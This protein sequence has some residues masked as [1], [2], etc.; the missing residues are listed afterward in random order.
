MSEDNV[1][2]KQEVHDTERFGMENP[3]T[4]P[5]M[6]KGEHGTRVLKN[7]KV[8]EVR[9]L[10]GNHVLIYVITEKGLVISAQG[11]GE[12]RNQ[13]LHLAEKKPVYCAGNISVQNG[14]VTSINEQSGGY[15]PE[16][17]HLPQLV[18]RE[19]ARNGFTEARSKFRAS[20]GQEP[21]ASAPS[22]APPR[23]MGASDA[24]PASTSS[25]VS[26]EQK[27]ASVSSSAPTAPE[28]KQEIKD[29]VERKYHPV[30][31]FMPPLA[32]PVTEQELRTVLTYTQAIFSGV[33]KGVLRC[34]DDVLHPIDNI[35]Y[36]L[37]QLVSDASIIA[38]ASTLQSASNHPMLEGV[39]V[40]HTLIKRDSKLYQDA[41]KRMR[42]RVNGLEQS[43]S[44]FQQA[45]S[46]ERVEKLAEFSTSLL[47][48]GFM[49]KSA[50][51]FI[52][53]NRFGQLSP[54]TF[55]I[56]G[57]SGPAEWLELRPIQ[58]LTLQEIRAMRDADLM[59]V[60]TQKG[61]LIITEQ[62]YDH[63][64]LAQGKPVRGAGDVY[65]ENGR[66][67]R[68]DSRSG[69]FAPQSENLGPLVEHVFQ[70]NGF[71]EVKGQFV[72]W[73]K[74]MLPYLEPGETRTIP[75]ISHDGVSSSLAQGGS[76]AFFKELYKE[77]GMFSGHEQSLSPF[78]LSKLLKTPLPDTKIAAPAAPVMPVRASNPQRQQQQ[79]R[80]QQVLVQE[81]LRDSALNPAVPRAQYRMLPPSSGFAPR[82][83][84]LF[85]P[86]G[87][88]YPLSNR[89]YAQSVRPIGLQW[90][91]QD[92]VRR[93][94]NSSF[95]SLT[96][97]YLSASRALGGYSLSY[98]EFS[99]LVRSTSLVSSYNR[100]H[101]AGS[102]RAVMDFYR[103]I[104]G[105]G[106]DVAHISDL[107]NS[108]AHLKAE[109]YLLCF[110]T[111]D[112]PIEKNQL[113]QIAHELY[114]GYFTHKTLP[115]FSLHF[116]N[117]GF[118]YPVI[119]P[120]YQNTLVGQVIGFLDY[121]MKGFLNGGIYDQEFLKT[122]HTLGNGDEAYLK[123]KVIL[124]EAYCKEHAPGLN[125]AS[126]RERQHREGISQ[127][128]AKSS[129]YRQPFITSFRIIAY[130][131]RIK[132]HEHI[133][134]PEPGFRV[135]YSIDPAPD[136]AQYLEAYRKQHGTY[137]EEY[138]SLR[139]VYK[140]QAEDICQ[141]M[142]Q[143]P[144]C[145]EFFKLLG[146]MNALCYFYMTLEKMG[147]RPV[148]PPVKRKAYHFPKALPPIPVRYFR[149]Y[150]L[151]ITLGELIQG[152]SP[153][154]KAVL[155]EAFLAELSK[156]RFLELPA[157]FTQ[158]MP[159]LVTKK[160]KGELKTQLAESGTLDIYL[161]E[162]TRMS[163]MA[164]QYV[165]RAA[166]VM[167]HKIRQSLSE[168]YQS[169]LPPLSSSEIKAAELK[170]LPAQIKALCV[171]K[172]ARLE[173]TKARWKTAPQLAKTEIY[174]LVSAKMHARIT[175]LFQT[176]EEQ[177]EQRVQAT[178]SMGID[179]LEEKFHA[180]IAQEKA[181]VEELQQAKQQLE[182][183]RHQAQANIAGLNQNISAQLAKIP[184][185][186]RAINQAGINQFL[187]GENQKIAGIQAT[188]AQMNSI[189]VQMNASIAQNSQEIAEDE[190]QLPAKL[191]EKRLELVPIIRAKMAALLTQAYHEQAVV[192]LEK[193]YEKEVSS[194]DN[195]SSAMQHF[196]QRLED[197]P[198]ESQPLVC[199]QYTH[200]VL[201]F[202]NPELAKQTG[203]R[204]RL[205][206]GCAF[207][208][209]HLECEPIENAAEFMAAV[210]E[211]K[212]DGVFAHMRHQQS[213]YVVLSLPV[214]NHT[215]SLEAKTKPAPSPAEQ[216]AARLEEM[217]EGK[218]TV[219]SYSSEMLATPIDSSG[220]TS[221][222]YAAS[223]MEEK[224][225][226]TL[227]TRARGPLPVDHLGQNPLHA[228]AMAGNTGVVNALL[229]KES[230]VDTQNQRGLTALM[231]AIQQGRTETVK[232][233]LA[234]GANVNHT[235]PN[236]LFPLFL[237]IQGNYPD[238]ALLL[239]QHPTH[240][241]VNFTL[242]SGQTALHLAIEIRMPEVA[243]RLIEKG[244]SC[245]AKRKT[246][247]YA[248]LHCAAHVNA[249]ELMESMV[250]RGVSVDMP[251]ESKKTPL[252]LAAEKG[253]IGA[254]SRLLALGANL[255]TSMCNGDTPLM[256]AIQNGHLAVAELLAESAALNTLNDA[257]QTASIMAI[258]SGMP[259]IADTLIARGE[260]PDL[261][262]TQG[263]D[264][265]YH[266]VCQG[267]YHRFLALEAK[268]A[269][270]LN[271]RY[272]EQNLLEIAAKNR[273]TL[274]VHH[275]VS[276]KLRF[277]KLSS[278]IQYVVA[279]DDVGELRQW[280]NRHTPKAATVKEGVDKDRTLA[281]LAFRAGAEQCAEVLIH[282]MSK[283]A[284]L[285]E[286]LLLASIESQQIALVDKVIQRIDDINMP[287]DAQQQTALHRAV[288]AGSCRLVEFLL[289]RGA[290]ARCVDRTGLT[291]FHLAVQY[292]DVRLLKRLLK[293]T[294]PSDWPLALWAPE[295]PA[296][297]AAI[298]KVLKQYQK[299]FPQSPAAPAPA[300]RPERKSAPVIVAR[301]SLAPAK[302]AREEKTRLSQLHIHLDDC[303][304]VRDFEAIIQLLESQPAAI[305][306]FGS[307]KEAYL[308]KLFANI[309]K[310]E[311]ARPDAKETKAAIPAAPVIERLLTLLKRS[312][313]D[314]SH[315]RGESNVLQAMT[316][317]E[318]RCRSL[319]PLGVVHSIFFGQSCAFVERY[320]C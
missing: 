74:Q 58:S 9:E 201:G 196:T 295:R 316:S 173:R 258:Q 272:D 312:G 12:N 208:L 252:H 125:Y 188:I 302:P 174:G 118:L 138:A 41:V 10:K 164:G 220:S 299:R 31:P 268:K 233:L 93:E 81:R 309:S 100:V 63:W 132:R 221:L 248:P 199:E 165:I 243:L 187:A 301:P 141:K 89:D 27:A 96:S 289:S 226:T 51:C 76:L 68:V 6:F 320:G 24:K 231:L 305:A 1:E 210:S 35:L 14:Q 95:P 234:A 83:F 251:L 131:K 256:L 134:I 267:E 8:N 129:A 140:Q 217:C 216:A 175:A 111:D 153:T 87:N 246:D 303:L 190:K 178:M 170:P 218:A 113:L 16:G 249:A 274:L 215:L 315:C 285:A 161:P 124:L 17:K 191:A 5:L 99:N 280:L 79:E 26:A 107:I 286:E 152:F 212:S 198:A 106:T 192:A 273:C 202:T 293:L 179:Q 151:R 200:A 291:V 3:P 7:L 143:L 223:M 91:V 69:S 122:W 194:L 120:A 159:E 104:G 313:I 203:E 61:K 11:E 139:R 146:A 237:A 34:V 64:H 28:R 168:Y 279:T 33:K 224:P 230:K 52:N 49:V 115:F 53:Y 211:A 86:V 30:D 158:K 38:A 92:A 23:R 73:H 119:H 97:A 2:R 181:E 150:P 298:T 222:H 163:N 20:Y 182:A 60:I 195:L 229:K 37:S 238:I 70:S 275:F 128:E 183:N 266:L 45:S 47:A 62:T 204:F 148:L 77:R 121:W 263:H 19:F 90:V 250:R 15:R 43:W 78:Y 21:P 169:M 94:L 205:H 177:H 255:N 130:Q 242:D 317:A 259:T 260:R 147:K 18:E 40:L 176:L 284:I 135:E 144:F 108:E 261:R 276:R 236:G 44:D 300:A 294:P 292:E 209:P 283:S 142:P 167:H 171:L 245:L 235:L 270:D 166:Q 244:A 72:D 232:A 257:K 57:S 29:Q 66:I 265:I 185:H 39:Q 116:N 136:Y 46:V 109:H 193:L 162:Q 71:P 206:G 101:T 127:P 282:S 227:L 189:I 102:I 197:L 307:S 98:T 277:K 296:T 55:H 240:K 239:L 149:D 32:Q 22:L 133:L 42:D 145:R 213:R 311:P 228:A 247:G 290:D 56:A 59:Y 184:A 75:I 262:D 156:P 287:L 288:M 157:L 269:V 214:Q 219:D 67:T 84:S 123:S 50:K 110:P 137:P 48:P 126:L 318:K 264:Y 314:P 65:V 103:D 114:E 88:F 54:P 297:S 278:F 271:Q 308:L 186:L 80:L 36:P 207:D 310:V 319:L 253:N 180:R 241:A 82:P 112:L 281:Y 105:V 155:D 154:E 4:F 225:F 306:L 13:H 25:L 117:E 254:V 304:L 172:K 85:S 160:I